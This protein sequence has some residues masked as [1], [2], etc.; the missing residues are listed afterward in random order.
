MMAGS[1][2]L[3]TY[4]TFNYLAVQAEKDLS[5]LY[6]E[7]RVAKSTIVCLRRDFMYQLVSWMFRRC[8]D[9]RQNRGTQTGFAQH[10]SRGTNSAT[11]CPEPCKPPLLLN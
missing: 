10:S 4:D 3:G 7:W 6:V 9:S 8:C 1:N 5:Y 11:E 2:T